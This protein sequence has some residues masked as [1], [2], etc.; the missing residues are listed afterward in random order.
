MG[1]C[2]VCGANGDERNRILHLIS[3]YERI[4]IHSKDPEER[5]YATRKI[6]LLQEAYVA[7]QG[8]QNR[9]RYFKHDGEL[10]YF[11]TNDPVIEFARYEEHGILM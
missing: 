3:A 4:V 2:A 11:K 8:R 7:L 1:N 9:H 6:N 10:P 5:N